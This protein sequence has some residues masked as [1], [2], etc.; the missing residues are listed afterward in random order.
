VGF[1]KLSNKQMEIFLIIAIIMAVLVMKSP[2]RRVIF[3]FLRGSLPYQTKATVIMSICF[4]PPVIFCSCRIFCVLMARDRFLDNAFYV[5]IAIINCSCFVPRVLF[6]YMPSNVR[7]FSEDFV[8]ATVFL[9]AVII[10]LLLTA[11]NVGTGLVHLTGRV[12]RGRSDCSDEEI[13]ALPDTNWGNLSEKNHD[14]AVGLLC[15][16]LYYYWP[17]FVIP[18]LLRLSSRG[19]LVLF[20][21]CQILL[22]LYVFLAARNFSWV[23][24]MSLEISGMIDAGREEEIS[25]LKSRLSRQLGLVKLSLACVPVVIAAGVYAAVLM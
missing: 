8:I 20:V 21:Q 15:L 4:L 19:W 10:F 22:I 14:M 16:T 12:E 2:L 1:V 23:R 18:R 6:G 25:G 13:V 3:L 11:T 5:D 7:L 24:G 9:T 17:L